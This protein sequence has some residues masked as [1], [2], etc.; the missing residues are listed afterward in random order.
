MKRQL[1]ELTN[2]EAKQIAVITD[3]FCDIESLSVDR[4]KDRFIVYSKYQDGGVGGETKVNIF[5]DTYEIDYKTEN[6]YNHPDSYR[7]FLIYQFLEQSGFD[8]HFNI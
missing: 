1:S 6:G 5:P 2:L 4:F 8:L 3:I 7:C